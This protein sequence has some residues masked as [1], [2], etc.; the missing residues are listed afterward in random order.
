MKE[1]DNFK[2]KIEK[3]VDLAIAES[4]ENKAIREKYLEESSNKKEICLPFGMEERHKIELY[5][6][7]DQIID[8]MYF[9][10]R[11]QFEKQNPDVKGL[12][13]K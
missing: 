1:Y 7:G 12:D 2:N 4:E 11:R 6:T 5:L 10:K 8:V 13:E 3:V 9:L